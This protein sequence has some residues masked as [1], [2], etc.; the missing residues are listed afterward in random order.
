MLTCKILNRARVLAERVLA[1]RV[2]AE[3]TYSAVPN[4]RGGARIND[5][6]WH[7]SKLTVYFIIA[8]PGRC[9]QIIAGIAVFSIYSRILIAFKWI[10]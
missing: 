10:A 3:S 9:L 8:I 1:E 7:I 5:F 4:R 2:L 6:W